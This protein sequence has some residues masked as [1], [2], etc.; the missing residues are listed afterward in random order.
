M[1]SIIRIPVDS[2]AQSMRRP[3]RRVSWRPDLAV[4]SDGLTIDRLVQHIITHETM[5]LVLQKLGEWDAS[6]KFDRLSRRQIA[7][8]IGHSPY[9]TLGVHRP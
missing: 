8:K 3:G 9:Y 1:E 6:R 2:F 5:H 7:A 4:R